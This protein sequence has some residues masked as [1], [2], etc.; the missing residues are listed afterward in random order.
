MLDEFKASDRQDQNNIT[1]FLKSCSS[2]GV[3]ESARPTTGITLTRGLKR[4][5]SSISISRRLLTRCSVQV[6]CVEWIFF[7]LRMTGRSNKV[8]QGMNTIITE[9]RITLDTW[10]FC[11]DIVVL[12]FQITHDFLEAAWM[13]RGEISHTACQSTP[14]FL[15]CRDPY[16]CSL[17]ILSPKP[18]VS[19][20]VNEILS[21]SPSACFLK[22]S[23]LFQST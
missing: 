8:Q 15:C 22:I 11:K 3:S 13:R 20:I 6:V 7:N 1:R 2:W 21:S 9:S 16:H 4:R 23:S 10:F 12:S 5:I 17:S 18:G 14:S 19:T